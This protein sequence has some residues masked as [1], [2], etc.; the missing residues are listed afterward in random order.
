MNAK[1]T[2]NRQHAFIVNK[3]N[4]VFSQIRHLISKLREVISSLF[5]VGEA[6]PEL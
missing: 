4:C 1:L 2:M 5:G 3:T 6:T